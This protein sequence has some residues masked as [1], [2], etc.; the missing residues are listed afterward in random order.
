ML[1]KAVRAAEVVKVV[2][3]ARAAKVEKANKSAENSKVSKAPITAEIEMIAEESRYLIKEV[4]QEYF[5]TSAHQNPC[6][7]SNAETFTIYESIIVD[8]SLVSIPIITTINP[9]IESLAINDLKTINT[10]KTIEL[11]NIITTGHTLQ[12]IMQ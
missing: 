8:T 10:L 6:K 4:E 9:S 7:F 5:K 12:N 11:E 2:E 3:A 1:T